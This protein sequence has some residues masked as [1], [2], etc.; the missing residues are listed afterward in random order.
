MQ[1]VVSITSQ[2]QI[3]IPQEIRQAFG[4]TGA[5]KA[6]IKK[7]DNSII[8]KPQLSFDDLA[9]SLKSDISLT[10]KELRQARKTFSKDWS[11]P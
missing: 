5:V 3:T 2:G 7:K 4:I 9:G 8:I 11:K 6:V 10:D 1:K